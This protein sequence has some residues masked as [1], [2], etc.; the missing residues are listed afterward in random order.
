MLGGTEDCTT[1]GF[2]AFHGFAGSAVIMND[3]GSSTDVWRGDG[4]TV[5]GILE[6]AD[7]GATVDEKLD[8]TGNS[9]SP[10]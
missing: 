2:I 7:D 9:S 1:T 6:E 5:D 10:L 3:L 8:G 4:A